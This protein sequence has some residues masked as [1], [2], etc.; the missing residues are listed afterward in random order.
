[1]DE[2]LINGLAEE[3]GIMPDFY[4]I[5]GIRHD[6]T[7]ETK[8]GVLKAMGLPVEDEGALRAFLEKKRQPPVLEPSVVAERNLAFKVN[9]CLPSCAGRIPIRISLE[10]EKKAVRK[11]SVRQTPE[12]VTEFG[13]QKYGRYLVD[14]GPLPQGYY[15]FSIHAPGG[16]RAAGDTRASCRLII[17]PRTCYLPGEQMRSWGVNL[18]LHGV[19]SEGNWGIGDF[20]DL[21]RIMDVV[22]GLGGDFAGILPLHQV[23]LPESVSPYWPISRLYRNFI[24][25]D[26]EGIP[27]FDPAGRAGLQQEIDAL[28]AAR[29]VDYGGVYALK[30]RVLREMFARFYSEHYPARTERGL[31]FEAFMGKEGEPLLNY[32]TFMVL[33]EVHGMNWKDWPQELKDPG[34]GPVNE[35]RRQNMGKVLFHVYV[36]WAIDCQLKGLSERAARLGMRAGLF[37]DQAIGTVSGGADD[38]TFRDCFASGASAGAPPDEF[39]LKGQNWGFPPMVPQKMRE[40]GYAAFIGTVSK[41]MAHA[42]MLRIDHALGLFRLFW[43]PEGMEPSQ[44]AYVKYPAE[45]MMGILAIESGRHKTVIVAEDLGTVDPAAREALMARNMLSYRLLIYERLYPSPDLVP[46]GQYPRLAFCAV[47]THD[48]PTLYGWWAGHDMQVK[49][50][51]SLYPSEDSYHRDLAA[52]ERDRGIILGALKK[53]GLISDNY[54]MPSDMNEELMLAI[55]R[56]LGRTPC[57]YVSVSIEDIF[58]S[59]EQPNLPG[60]GDGYPNWKIKTPMPIGSMAGAAEPFAASF[61][62]EGRGR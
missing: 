35:F 42:G 40:S 44:G 19:R 36:Q 38:W 28:T 49:R 31:A 12:E 18:A 56:H 61:R 25:L 11:W 43:I 34:S 13:G 21:G 4:D 14:V 17:A 52:R 47:S 45:E 9:V 32:A 37:L 39:N 20:R 22:A 2:Q 3:M 60:S 1:M 57:L 15:M 5:W 53:E 23:P 24:F 58:K 10:D 29:E 6:V 55:Y 26:L 7:I 41:N 48:L 33:S 16:K 30:L 59:F 8:V 27:E 46:P 62:Q 54:E 50:S 51:L